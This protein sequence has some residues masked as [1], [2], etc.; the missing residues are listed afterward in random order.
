[1]CQFGMLS[2]WNS[3][4]GPLGPVLQLTCTLTNL[5]CLHRE[6]AKQEGVTQCLL[7]PGEIIIVPDNWNDATALRG[8]HLPAHPCVPAS[9]PCEAPW[10]LSD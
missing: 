6:L 5:C 8:Q 4:D 10:R 2:H 3:K 1:M 9:S 7:L